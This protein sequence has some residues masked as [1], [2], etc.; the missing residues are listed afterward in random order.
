MAC[1]NY[2]TDLLDQIKKVLRFFSDIFGIPESSSCRGK[3]NEKYCSISLHMVIII[4]II[5]SIFSIFLFGL[6]F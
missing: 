2:F 1:N 5:M 6:M 3:I 4:L